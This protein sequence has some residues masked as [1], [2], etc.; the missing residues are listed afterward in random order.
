MASGPAACGWPWLARPSTS[1]PSSSSTPADAGPCSGASSSCSRRTRSSI[2]SATHAW[3][4]RRGPQR[5]RAGSTTSTSTSSRSSAAGSGRSR[6]ERPITSVGVV[7]EKRDFLR[8]ACRLTS[9]HGSTRCCTRP[10]TAPSAMQDA[11]RINE[12]KREGDYSYRMSRFTGPGYLMIGDAARFVDPIF[13]S[14]VSVACYSAK[15]ASRRSTRS[16]GAAST[17]GRRSST[18]RRPF[19][20][21]CQHLVRVHLLVLSAAAAVHAVHSERRLIAC[22]SCGCCKARCSSAAR[23]RCSTPCGSS[24]TAVEA[25]DEHLMRPYLGRRQSGASSTSCGRPLSSAENSSA[26]TLAQR[27]ARDAAS[28]P[29]YAGLHPCTS[30]RPSLQSSLA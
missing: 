10:P 5:G 8:A 17:S 14:G 12:F 7:V 26:H 15:F 9:K 30:A 16:C 4:E 23:S 1:R 29:C 22:R 3:F 18:T 25:N 19:G 28:D 11:V 20:A 21:G 6:S 27:G 24:S 2:N 13:S